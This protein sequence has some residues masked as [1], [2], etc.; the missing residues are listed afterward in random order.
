MI[1][2]TINLTASASLIGIT[3]H[4]PPFELSTPHLPHLPPLVGEPGGPP[5]ELAEDKALEGAED[6]GPP[7]PPAAPPPNPPPTPAGAAPTPEDLTP[8]PTE[9]RPDAPPLLRL[10]PASFV[11]PPPPPLLDDFRSSSSSPSL[12]LIDCTIGVRT[13]TYT[14]TCI[15]MYKYMLPLCKTEGPLLANYT[16]SSQASQWFTPVLTSGWTTA[17]CPAH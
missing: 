5:R 11:P 10:P 3:A 13:V 1:K 17:V 4:R 8:P 15:L 2:E 16:R 14:Y 9:P 7:P 6:I 12:L